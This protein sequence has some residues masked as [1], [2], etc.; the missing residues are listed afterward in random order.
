MGTIEY[1]LKWKGKQMVFAERTRQMTDR[2][3]R[4]TL[5]GYLEWLESNYPEDYDGLV[6]EA[7]LGGWMVKAENLL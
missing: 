5:I 7:E 2:R 1:E 4:M 6:N 3:T